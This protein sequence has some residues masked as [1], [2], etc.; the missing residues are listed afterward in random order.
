MSPFAGLDQQLPLYRT[1]ALLFSSW[2]ARPR[3]PA[4]S[5]PTSSAHHQHP[6]L[7]SCRRHRLPAPTFPPIDHLRLCSPSPVSLPAYIHRLCASSVVEDGAWP[8]SAPTRQDSPTLEL[9]PSASQQ[10]IRQANTC[11]TIDLTTP[12]HHSR[13][14]PCRQHFR[15]WGVSPSDTTTNILSHH[16]SLYYPTILALPLRG[17]FSRA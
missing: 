7:R 9:E 15:P 6:S 8:D 12:R 13:F 3:R 17:W 10:T 2:G 16:T 5:S 4:G 1:V 11:H 14:T